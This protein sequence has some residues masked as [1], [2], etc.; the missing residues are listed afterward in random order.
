MPPG[1]RFLHFDSICRF[2]LKL[3]HIVEI[4]DRCSQNENTTVRDTSLDYN[5]TYKM[6]K[7]SPKAGLCLTQLTWRHYRSGL[8]KPD[9]KW[10]EPLGIASDRIRCEAEWAHRGIQWLAWH[11]SVLGVTIFSLLLRNRNQLQAGD[12]REFI[13]C[14]AKEEHLQ[15]PIVVLRLICLSTE[16]NLLLIYNFHRSPVCET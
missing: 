1:P 5:R 9:K 13:S 2:C 14:P 12:D 16:S 7:G 10:W 4:L 3:C 8:L 15:L 6:I 11:R